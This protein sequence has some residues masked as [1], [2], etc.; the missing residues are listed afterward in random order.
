VI[1]PADLLDCLAPDEQITL[2]AHEL[3]H[4]RRRDHWVRWL[5][6]VVTGVYW[7]LP[8]VWWARR[9]LGE[10][11]EQCCD[12][13]V[14]WMLPA[15]AKVYARALLQT[16]DFLDTRPALPPAASGLGHLYLLKRRLTMIVHERLSPRLPWPVHAGTVLLGMLI[17]PMAPQRL[18]ADSPKEP[19]A[20]AVL[21][22]D[23]AS[24]K[25]SQQLRELERRM[26]R[27]EERLDRALRAIETRTERRGRTEEVERNK[28]AS[29]EDR[30]RAL[31]ERKRA[32]DQ[33]KEELKKALEVRK[34]AMKQSA[35][36]RKKALDAQ[37]KGLEEAARARGKS[38]FNFKFEWKA[39]D[40]TKLKDL[41][42]QIQEMVNKTFSP[43]RMK[44]LEKQIQGLVEKNI[45]PEQMKD[46]D[47]QIQRLV[48]RT[49]SPER[50]QAL[51]K[52]IEAIVARSMATEQRERERRP[53]QPRAPQAVERPAT[54]ATPRA[55][56]RSSGSN[57]RDLE[58][59]LDNL[60]RKMDRVLQALE[61]RQK[62]NKE[63]DE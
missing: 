45:N 7:W 21:A 10:A 4:A 43:E 62:G 48:E 29:S 19:E 11:E 24:D 51:Q 55:I 18:Q 37:R 57:Q 13:W 46:V 40:K 23:D 14:V 26:T 47:R 35:E 34:E 30:E 49:V 28:D 38:D 6:F 17:L 12:A 54:P 61:S 50:I 41:D 20:V 25:S 39:E 42:K 56:T 1:L 33:R 52:Q 53:E 60:E 2:L 27:L 32:L 58:R 44:D 8:V 15:A 5:E 22:D 31:A 9:R 59:R 36:A 16:V 3:A 63:R